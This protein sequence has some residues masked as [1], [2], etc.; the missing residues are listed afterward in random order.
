MTP[1][2]LTSSQAPM[3]GRDVFWDYDTPES[4][5]TRSKIAAKMEN[6]AGSPR[7][8]PGETL[9]QLRLFRPKNKSRS[10]ASVGD[11]HGGE[12]LQNLSKL[13]AE[14]FKKSEDKDLS[15]DEESRPES[16]TAPIVK[17]EEIIASEE[18]NFLE[19]DLFGDSDP[20]ADADD[21][22]NAYL[23]AASQ[24][25]ED[26]LQPPIP[27]V[28][29]P[30]TSVETKMMLPAHLDPPEPPQTTRSVKLENTD[31]DFGDDSF[32]DLLSQM[33]KESSSLL[34]QP[35]VRPSPA[36]LLH[37]SKPSG[38]S[39]SQKPANSLK[40]NCSS[41]Q[42]PPSKKIFVQKFQ[43]DSRIEVRNKLPQPNPRCSKDEI[44]RKRKEALERRKVSLSQ[45]RAF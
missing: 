6:M 45:K 1:T 21:E 27:P 24:V 9:T 22:D 37:Q 20:F 30:A 13:N 12:V 40:R 17:K 8:K 41:F 32:E 5:R 25:V 39:S 19:E 7:A 28:P 34:Q 15:K 4:R 2:R 10:S 18:T 31:V 42:S 29:A 43:S 11:Q 36:P 33:E 23:I 3:S 44:E 38:A 16:S 35:E 14:I 26:D